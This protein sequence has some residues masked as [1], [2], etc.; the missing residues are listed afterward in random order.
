MY[1]QDTFFSA[2]DHYLETHSVADFVYNEYIGYEALYMYIQSNPEFEV[3]FVLAYLD[4]VNGL[5]NEYP[6]LPQSV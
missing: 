3:E 6:K 4:I 2:I 1:S 5:P